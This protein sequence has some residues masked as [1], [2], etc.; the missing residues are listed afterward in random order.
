MKKAGT[1]ELERSSCFFYGI[2]KMLVAASAG[3]VLLRT[4]WILYI[5]K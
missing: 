5:M 1:P 2:K 4:N 3:I